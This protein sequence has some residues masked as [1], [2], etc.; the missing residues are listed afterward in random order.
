M[1]IADYYGENVRRQISLLSYFSNPED[2]QIGDLCDI[3]IT[4]TA[5]PYAMPADSIFNITR[6]FDPEQFYWKDETI[7]L[8]RRTA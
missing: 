1:W 3:K 5:H 7:T 8:Y 2:T 6:Y 4:P